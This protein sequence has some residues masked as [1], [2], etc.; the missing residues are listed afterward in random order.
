M[1]E[2][3]VRI[4]AFLLLLLVTVPNHHLRSQ[5]FTIGDSAF[6]LDG[7]PFQIRSGEMHAARIPPEYWRHRLQMVHAMGCNTV[8]AYLFWNMHEPQP[9]MF[10]FTG[11]ANAAEYC[12][13]ARDEGLKVILRPGPYSCAE[14][15]FG[16]LP[17]WLL[18]Y[19]DIKVRTRDARYL[20]AVRR[21]FIEVGKQLSPL[22]IT[23]G[24]P[25]IM[26]QVENEYGS[27]GS[28]R[29]YI[30]SV[31]DYLKEAGFDVP[32]FTCDG[33]SQLPN[34]TRPEIFSVVNFGGDPKGSFE[35]LRK[36]RPLGPLMCGEYYPGWFDSWGKQHHT[37]STENV[38]NDLR[39]MLEH[40]ASFSIYMVHGGT[41]FGF[42]A[43][44]NSPPFLPQ[45]TSYDYDAP[46]DEMGRSTPK[47]QAIRELFAK[48]LLPGESLPDI[49]P[50]NPVIGV[51]PV[52]LNESA[53]LFA[54]LGPGHRVET[55][56]PM[57]MFDQITGCILYR[58]R[59]EAGSGGALKIKEAHDIARIFV[60]GKRVGTLDRRYKKKTPLAI[61]PFT[62]E[63]T[64][65]IL[66]EAMGRV[67]YGKDIHDRK[68]ITE[69]VELFDGKTTRELTGWEV[70]TL[71]LDRQMLGGLKFSSQTIPGPAFHR[72][73]FK[74]KKT[75]DTFLDMHGWGKGNVWV[76]GHHLGR[77]WHIG[78]Q[79]TLYLPGVWL[80]EGDNEIV[81]LELEDN[82]ERTIAGLTEP[83]LNR[84]ETDESA[85]PM[86]VRPHGVLRLLSEDLVKRGSFPD[87]SSHQDFAFTPVT[88]RF[89]CLQ[90]LSSQRD[91]PFASVSELYVLDTEHR[92]LQRD[93]WSVEFVD[94]EELEAE[95]GRAEN[96]FDDDAETIWHSQWS[97]SKPQHPHSLVIDLGE[98]QTVCGFRYVPRPTNSP[99][100]IKEFK[101]YARAKPFE[102]VR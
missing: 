70:Y 60:D 37:G 59:L 97:A 9:G 33:A 69:K 90:S 3:G 49:P 71:P 100:R 23:H 45:C 28:D 32:F 35:S 57:E 75:G 83:I 93:K 95:D 58:T 17:S 65:D 2:I 91:D 74:L 55:P 43:G 81:A 46:I 66:V 68:G 94:S 20:D 7:K 38:L 76:N 31:R 102:I 54:N 10:D 14:W 99:G 39:Y 92:P 52:E 11:P 101:F 63:V 73:V 13:I 51:P 56:L 22:Q 67:N 72:G 40:N 79:Q 77:F 42:S 47:Y 78:P 36:I 5:T 64:L 29:E 21:Y 18:K 84:V 4:V 27:Y 44:A 15:E 50:P 19:S 96:V 53:G 87:G 12:R 8:C 85:P 26:V 86:P 98:S 88:C 80:K 61:G 89:I 1:K 25:I 34:D 62:S 6:L 82:Q 41:S 30:G 24:G 16:G 48:H